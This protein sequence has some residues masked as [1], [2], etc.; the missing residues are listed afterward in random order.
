MTKLMFLA[1]LYS[2]QL[3]LEQ[4]LVKKIGGHCCIHVG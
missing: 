2:V 3:S 1:T 4:D